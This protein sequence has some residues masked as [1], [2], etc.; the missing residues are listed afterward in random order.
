MGTSEV[1]FGLT[2]KPRLD[3]AAY[4][5]CLNQ[6]CFAYGRYY[7]IANI[8]GSGASIEW[9][10]QILSVHGEVGY[11]LSMDPTTPVVVGMWRR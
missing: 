4:E 2:D 5:A 1:Y 10:R 11:E 8:P 9:L 7:W 6:G 3:E